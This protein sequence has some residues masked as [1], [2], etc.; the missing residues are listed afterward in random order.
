[1]LP[2]EH[3][4]ERAGCFDC[5]SRRSLALPAADRLKAFATQE[6]A[7]CRVPRDER[8]DRDLDLCICNTR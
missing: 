1:V 4:E 8:E 7:L 5:R 3:G 2:R 6:E